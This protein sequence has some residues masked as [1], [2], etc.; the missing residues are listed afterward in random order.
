MDQ[1][2]RDKLLLSEWDLTPTIIAETH[3]HADHITSASLYRETYNAK[4]AVS[5]YGDVHGADYYLGNGDILEIKGAVLQV[6][7]TPGHTEESLCYLF[8]Q[9]AF[10]GD[11]LLIRGCGRTDFQGGSS[12]QLFDSVTQ[13]LFTLAD[14]TVVYPGHDYKGRL[15]ST[16]AEEKKHNPRLTKNKE[17]F[18]ELMANLGLS[19][20]KKMDVAVPANNAL[21]G[22]PYLQT[23]A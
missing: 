4:I 15:W 18:C 13:K 19:H 14:D 6:L 2:E 3:T 1:F 21:G 16:V 9:C 20:P 23:T 22:L 11:T 12:E 17:E 5:A 8:D 7:H 10:T